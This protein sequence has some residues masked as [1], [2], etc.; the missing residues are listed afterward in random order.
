MEFEEGLPVFPAFERATSDPFLRQVEI[1]KKKWVILTD[2]SGEPH[3]VM[4]S[5]AFL[6]DALFEAAPLNPLGYCHRPI[7]VKSTSAP[8][9][10]VLCQLKECRHCVRDDI[11]ERDVV[12]IWGITEKRL[13]TGADILGRLLK[14]I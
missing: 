11:I 5:D 6:R 9:G 4:D 8:L 2:S 12:L 10:N 14:G 1:S 3:F 7:I 13:I